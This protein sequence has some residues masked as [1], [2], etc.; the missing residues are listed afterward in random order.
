MERGIC[1]Q[2]AQWLVGFDLFSKGKYKDVEMCIYEMI[3]CGSGVLTLF[4]AIALFPKSHILCC[5]QSS[6]HE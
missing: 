2:Y 3:A 5:L 6:L 1:G 4:V